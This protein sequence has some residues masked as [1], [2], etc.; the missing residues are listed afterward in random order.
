[1]SNTVYIYISVAF[2]VAS[3][4]LSTIYN[5]NY[6]DKL[7]ETERKKYEL[8]I[9]ERIKVYLI[10][11]ICAFLFVSLLFFCNISVKIKFIIC[12]CIHQFTF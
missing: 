5:K 4:Y 8:V 10:A 12:G 3:I 6:F 11:T 7:N 1:M 9:N 2:F